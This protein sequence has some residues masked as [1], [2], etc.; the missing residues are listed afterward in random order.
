LRAGSAAL[1]A[2]ALLT[3]TPRSAAAQQGTL[4]VTAAAQ[5]MHGDP[6]RAIGQPSLEPD[7]GV[8]WFQPGTRLGTLQ[9]D[10][11]GTRRDGSPHLGR[12]LFSARDLK[13]RGGTWT[14]EAGDTWFSPLVGEYKFANLSAPALTF[15]G[16]SVA[17]RAA[18]FSTG[19]LAGRTT[20]S[21]NL[22]GSDPDT[23]AQDLALGRAS[24]RPRDGLELVARASR[25]R[26]GHIPNHDPA[27]AASDQAGIAARW[28][29][30]PSLHVIG[31]GAMVSFR[32][33]GSD[34]RTLD[35]SGIAGASLLLSRGWIQVNAARFSPGDLP[36]INQ[37]LTD[38][39]T[40][41]AAGELDA[42]A[43]ARVFGAWE[44]SR[45][46]H[47]PY[48]I[49]PA[50]AGRPIPP[51]RGIRG[52][53]GIRTPLGD[54]TS[55]AVRVETGTRESR[56]EGQGLASLTDSGMITAEWQ[57]SVGTMSGVARYSH[58]RQVVSRSLSESHDVDDASGHLFL[59]LGPAAQVFGNAAATRT[60]TREGGGSSFW[61]IGGG[62]QLQLR[63]RTLW[64]RADG[65]ISRNVD[66][67]SALAVPQRSFNV[68]L[69]GEIFANTIL[70]VNLNADRLAPS[71]ATG[72]SW[73]ARSSVRVTRTFHTG[74]PRTS[75]SISSS[76]ARLGGTGS[77]AGVVFS[78]WN[79]NGRQDPGEALLENIP[80]RL[81][82]LG[83]ASTSTEGEFA[84]LSVPIGMQVVGI[85]LAALP[86]DF[87][88]PAIAQV[89]LQIGRGEVKRVAF[90]L[91]PLTSVSGRVVLD[92][93]GNGS[94]DPGEKPVE[95][96]IVVLDG[97]LRSE[98]V[99]KGRFTFDAVRTGQHTL[100]LLAD[101]L[102][103]GVAVLGTSEMPVSLAPSQAEPDV[104]FLV[105]IHARAELRRVFASAPMPAA[106]LPRQA[107]GS[108]RR[109]APAGRTGGRGAPARTTAA[110][111]AT[112][113]ESS[114][115]V[116]RFAVQVAA[117]DDQ[118]RAR[119]TLESLERLGLPAY[120]VE[121]PAS[122]PDAPYRVRV[123]RYETRAEAQQV[124]AGLQKARGE[125]FWVIRE[126]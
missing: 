27:I 11:R 74:S 51:S 113:V 7:A 62:G 57:A 40:F 1:A 94:A 3:L 123:G 50:R 39:R 85:D 43:R 64:V 26:T 72:P 54:R 101:S 56:S 119:R 96:A 65:N 45:S 32:R 9:V 18:R 35:G 36:V 33:H 68:G 14:I 89:Q 91:L 106:A 46:N 87:D 83:G 58:R 24:Y 29:A 12:A 10:L 71:D 52:F 107:A 22:F 34:I 75:T 17:G 118:T 114:Q 126:R 103:D 25:V 86:V 82:S 30:K 102:P 28:I 93:N 78:D 122:D 117:F 42:F 88:P 37:P 19:L 100:A 112:M 108:D 124:A 44:A 120:I 20:V 105:A 104:V 125:R 95:G 111:S 61:Q 115:G 70:G 76:L 23:I 81:S 80:V 59:A 110:G 63:E 31:D 60:D 48:S 99:R 92:S 47:D 77:V 66:I 69:N 98:R 41:F 16:G 97:G 4:Q 13:Y 8:S 116:Q 73:I 67:L 109:P 2:C 5:S 84:F 6:R 15:A 121:P 49:D 55:L 79:A 38:R 53:G 21:R 90:G